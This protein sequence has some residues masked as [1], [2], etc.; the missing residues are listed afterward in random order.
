MG[1]T[2]HGRPAARTTA[3]FVGGLVV[4]FGVLQVVQQVASAFDPRPVITASLTIGIALL[5]ALVAHWQSQASAAK[6]QAQLHRL[7]AVHPDEQPATADAIALGVFPGT[8]IRGR[9]PPYVSREIDD[10]LRAAITAGTSVVVVGP[11]RAGKSRTALEA[12]RAAADDAAIIAPRGPDEL[13]ALLGAE[14]RLSVARARRILWLDDLPQYVESLDQPALD[15][16]RD[17]FPSAARSEHDELSVVATVR[18]EEWLAMLAATGSAGQ[19]ARGLADRAEVYRLTPTDPVFEARAGSVYPSV[20]FPRGP[21]DALASSGMEAE[22]PERPAP[23]FVPA[24]PERWDWTARSL[25]AGAA[26]AGLI[27]TVVL[28]GWGFSTPTPP[29]MAA[30]IA[31]IERRAAQHGQYVRQ[32]VGGALDLH[33]S[34]QESRLFVVSDSEVRRGEPAPSD[35][36]R[37]YDDEGG[38]LRHS[39]RFR[40]AEPGVKFE[41]RGARDVDGD[42]AVEVVGG[43][44]APDARNAL[45]PLALDWQSSAQRYALVPLDLGPPPLGS[46]ELPKRFQVQ[47]RLYREKY[48][49]A[50]TIRDVSSSR[51]LTGHRVQEFEL[52]TPLRIVAAYFLRPPF[53]ISKDRALYELHA[54]ILKIGRSPGLTR[55]ELVGAPPPRMEILLSE[56]SQRSALSETW[57]RATA[58]RYCGVVSR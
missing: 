26:I 52:A 13:K 6:A 17:Y 40:P 18:E 28:V 43:Y 53:D 50:V 4:V 41:F 51:R 30:Q 35:E 46:A 34:G 37:V 42:G 56:R 25:A 54:A 38:W 19:L 57:Q 27:T 9:T 16:L 32:V 8:R 58:N 49:R 55:C 31:A 15:R 36:L 3:T 24:D 14:P 7:L 21:G 22:A 29:P 47:A 10:K 39:F 1:E 48:D 11:A 2:S 12:V 5:G 44:A 45:L 23:P 33:G 20:V